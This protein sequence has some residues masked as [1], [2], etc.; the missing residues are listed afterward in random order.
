MP[1]DAV[2]FVERGIKDNPGDWRLYYHWGFI[3]YIERHDYQSAADAFARGATVAG[4]P[5]WM[6]AMPAPMLQ[7]A[8]DIGTAR[9]L[10]TTMH[11]QA[12][13]ESMRTAWRS[14]T[15]FLLL[16]AQCFGADNVLKKIVSAVDARYNSLQSFKADFVET[17][18]GN[19]ILRRESGT[20]A[21]KRPGKMR[22]DYREPSQKL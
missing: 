18:T 6:N 12:Q 7:R 16:A 4:N 10:W 15:I 9:I 19:G 8:G 2:N 11:E 14:A 13:D 22:W 20:L 17:Y 1:D 3:H 5:P 21:L